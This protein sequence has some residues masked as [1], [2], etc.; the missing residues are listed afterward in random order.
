MKRINAGNCRTSAKWLLATLLAAGASSAPC[1]DREV[2]FL[3][4]AQYYRAPTPSREHW[5][6]DLA[7]MKAHGFDTVKFWVQWR[8]SERR[9]G[10]Y[11]WED[12]DELMDLAGKN[13][14]RV[15][16]NLILDVMPTWVERDYPE[17]LMKTIDGRTIKGEA[18]LYRQ[19][20]GYPGPCY[21]NDAMTAKRRRF[22]R[23]AFEHFKGHPALWGWDVWNEPERYGSMRDSNVFPQL[24]YCESCQAKFRTF[25]AEKYGTVERLN[26]IWGRCYGSFDEVEVP[27]THGTI[28]D[29]VDWREFQMGVLHADAAWR[30]QV[31]KEVDPGS[32]AH[33]HIVPDCGGFNP[34]TGVDDFL[35]AEGCEVYGSSMVNDPYLCAEG[36]SSGQGRRFYNAE[37]H[38]NWGRH[39]IFPRVIARDYFMT[40]QLAQLGWGIFGYLFWQYRTERLGTESPAWGMVRIDG[41]DRP[42]LAHA[43]EFITAFRPY[44][45][46]FMRCSTA[47]PKVLI[48]R[49]WANEFHQFCRYAEDGQLGRYHRAMRAYCKALYAMNVPYGFCTTET[50]EKGAGDEACVLVLPQAMYLGARDA[51]AFRAFAAKPGNVVFAEGNLGAY[52]RDANRYSAAVPGQGLAEAW[53]VREVEMTAAMHLPTE[54]P[55]AENIEGA[56]DV[57]K[58]MRSSGVRGDR[59]FPL[60]GTDGE[61]GFGAHDFLLVSKDGETEVLAAF[62][63][64]PCVVRRRNVFYAGTQLGCAAEEKDSHGLLIS[65]LKK[66]IA[67]SGTDVPA[68]QEGLHVDVLTDESGEARF[69]IAINNGKS[70]ASVAAPDAS[71][72][73]LFGGSL[74]T[75]LAPGQ[76]VLY[77]RP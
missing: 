10:E 14:L 71:W 11:R 32:V 22:A 44:A 13:G 21:A 62:N 59:H 46:L 34:L 31:L 26:E 68:H 51:A 29:F 12:L 5:A 66:A 53:G 9:E 20:G 27:R 23:A 63:G 16:L 54:A 55:T 67:A 47:K 35:C 60:W 43:T 1:G 33:L 52:D 61:R 2:P 72:K 36:V 15:V 48:W 18:V 58:A 38:I 73:E 69:M 64:A 41:S 76:S 45:D 24:C 42:T 25:V 39:D 19:L 37:W 30:L 65:L 49:G 57:A 50:L 4:G 75:T 28:A 77:V 56:D 40:E 6:E 70:A 17:S 8:W 7:G 3:Y 74:N